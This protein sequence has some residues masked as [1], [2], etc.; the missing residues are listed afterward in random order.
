[1]TTLLAALNMKNAAASKFFVAY[2]LGFNCNTV[3][4]IWSSVER[5]DDLIFYS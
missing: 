1:M 2:S 5:K 4:E 3:L